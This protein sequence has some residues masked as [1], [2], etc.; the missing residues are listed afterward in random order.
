M[1]PIA[2]QIGSYKVHSYGIL[3][4]LAFLTGVWR[5]YAVARSQRSRGGRINPDDV[6]DLGLWATVMGVIGARLLF[7]LIGWHSYRQHPADILK[8]WEGGLS[9][10]GG[11]ILATLAGIILCLRRRIPVLAMADICGPSVMIAYAVGR[12]GCFLNGCCYGAPTTMPWGL[13]F[14]DD[15]STTGALTP[16]SQ[17]TQLYA[18][19]LA[20]IFFGV[21]VWMERRKA[22]DGQIMC[23]YLLL[24]GVERFVMEIWRA[25]VTSDVVAFGLTDTQ[26]WCLGLIVA[27]TVGIQILRR[28]PLAMR[29]PTPSL[30]AVGP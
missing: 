9:F 29:L 6:L 8:V 23:W 21:L 18:T 30:E 12:V 17:P 19:G 24:A 4:M 20:L 11:L 28:R 26:L 1:F 16:P 14:H 3:L 27:A 25:G 10:H 22:Y 7:V 2:F 13:R 15:G 5:G